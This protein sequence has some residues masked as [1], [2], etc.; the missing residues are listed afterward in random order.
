MI[1]DRSVDRRL[2]SPLPARLTQ[3]KGV[4]FI[5]GREFHLLD[6]TVVEDVDAFVLCTGYKY[7]FP[8]LHENCDVRVDE[9]HVTPLYRHLVNIEHPT[10]CIVGVPT[11]VVPFP[12]FH[13]QV[14]NR[15]VFRSS[16]PIS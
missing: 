12:L 1:V 7:S 16:R 15:S 11:T 4:A 13:M 6:E 5:R 10:M 8:F 14:I 2:T 3:V 9:N